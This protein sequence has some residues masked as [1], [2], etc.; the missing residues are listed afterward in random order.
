M[1]GKQAMTPTEFALRWY[2]HTDLDDPG[3][4]AKAKQYVSHFNSNEVNGA[5]VEFSGSGFF[6]PTTDS[7]IADF[8]EK[9][10]AT[11]GRGRVYLTVGPVRANLPR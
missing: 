9:V 5:A 4:A 7:S 2:G 6:P 3:E 10:E 8:E 11:S 1:I